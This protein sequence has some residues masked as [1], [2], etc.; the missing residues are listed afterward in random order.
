[1]KSIIQRVSQAR[2]CIA[3]Q[4]IAEIGV[5]LVALIGIAPEDGL[6]Q[7]RRMLQRIL[8]Y[9][10]FADTQGRMNLSLQ[11]I[12]GGLLLV[13]NFTLMAN[14]NKGM[15]PSFAAAAEPQQAKALFTQM[16]EMAG[17]MHDH[18]GFGQFGADMQI[19]LCNDGPI[20]LNLSV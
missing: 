19:H 4:N 9:R 8:G 2:L 10:V 16:C 1:M 6:V 5:G 14:T 13:P 18:C 7:A 15:R 11:D 3:E 12:H 20:T 17:E